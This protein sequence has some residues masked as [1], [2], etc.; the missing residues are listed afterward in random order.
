MESR[1]RKPIRRPPQPARFTPSITARM[2]S[3]SHPLR[4][5]VSAMAATPPSDHRE[6]IPRLTIPRTPLFGR[7]AEVT[8]VSALLLR[9]DVPLV[10]LVGPGGVGKTRLALHLA[11]DCMRASRMVLSSWHWP[12]SPT[13]RSCRPR[14]FTRW[15]STRRAVSRLR[16][17]CGC[18]SGPDRCC[19]CST[20][21]NSSST[22]RRSW[23]ILLTIDADLTL[24]VTS[25]VPLRLQAERE[26]PVLPLA[27]PAP[28]VAT[29]DDLT[30]NPAVALFVQRVQA[31][32]PDYV[33]TSADAASV[34]EICRQLDGLPLAIEL[35]AARMRVLSPSGLLARLSNRLALLTGGP[36][37]LPPGIRRC[38]TR[39]PGAM[40]CSVQLSS[41]CCA[42]SLSSLMA[43]R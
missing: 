26:F 24:L 9:D 41:G 33:L 10:T 11:E 35:A 28:A 27:L 42:A 25:R 16:H 30:A 40:T 6:S 21:S 8:A 12:R 20:T 13:P 14:S 39:S 22:R 7:D 1:S 3:S 31:I 32:R 18:I 2:I 34:A 37:D 38:A 29:V 17:S 43:A 19:L 4:A 23:P 5:K 15:V 36:R